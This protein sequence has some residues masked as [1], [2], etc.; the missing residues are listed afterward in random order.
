M[1]VHPERFSPHLE[2]SFD[3]PAVRK[4][5]SQLAA[6]DNSG[7]RQ[8][9]GGYVRTPSLRCSKPSRIREFG[10]T[11][12]VDFGAGVDASEVYCFTFTVCIATSWAR[13]CPA[14]DA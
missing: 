10:V 1:V 12:V 8:G 5:S 6:I 13:V 2:L 3:D 14:F 11:T 4:R 7:T 9:D